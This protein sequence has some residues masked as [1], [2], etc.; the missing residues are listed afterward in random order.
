MH[1]AS[2]PPAAELP[3]PAVS[4]HTE[5]RFS[6]K[7][8]ARDS[9]VTELSLLLT[10]TQEPRSLSLLF[11]FFDNDGTSAVL[12]GYFFPAEYSFTIKKKKKEGNLV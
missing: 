6:A 1:P 2:E 7:V 12:T 9:A 3:D 11:N 8:T 10:N 4:F 5:G